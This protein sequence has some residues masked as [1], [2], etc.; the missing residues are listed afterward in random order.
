M[1]SSTPRPDAIFVRV[2]SFTSEGYVPEMSFEI[3][4]LE[5]PIALATSSI[6][7]A[8]CDL[9]SFFSNFA[10]TVLIAMRNFVAVLRNNSNRNVIFA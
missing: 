3:V 6:L 7:F 2:L 8:S 5:T 4:A 9:T 1:S 10:F